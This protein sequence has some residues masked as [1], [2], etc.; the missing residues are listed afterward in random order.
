LVEHSAFS[1]QQFA[2]VPVTNTS[3]Q[4]GLYVTGAGGSCVLPGSLYPR[5]GHP[6]LY[7]FTWRSGRVLP[8]FQFVFITE[9]KGE[10]ETRKSGLK[11]VAAGTMLIL[12]PDVWHRYRPCK[13]TGWTEYWISVNGDLMYDWQHR[14]LVAAS[15]SVL[16]MQEPEVLIRQYQEIIRLLK[17]HPRHQPTS[18]S[19]RALMIIA[20]VIDHIE[21]AGPKLPQGSD[22]EYGSLVSAAMKEIWSHSHQQISVAVIAQTLNV[23]R[24]TLER[25]FL[26]EVGYGVHAELMQCRLDRARRLLAETQVPIK[27]VAFASGFSSVSNMSRVFRR[28]LDISPSEY[29][30]GIQLQSKTRSRRS[31]VD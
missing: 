24:R 29:R 7:D 19:A 11:P 14:G 5:K 2:Y 26:R 9:G 3:I 8:E 18:V 30:E 13:N 21:P 27:A 25:N 4:L 16:Q 31:V 1:T 10:F 20:T 22:R 12:R 15:E 17:K 6:E 23:E 28:E